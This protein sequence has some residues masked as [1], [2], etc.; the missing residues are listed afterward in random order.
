V[1]GPRV[2]TG[3]PVIGA[4]VLAAGAGR[5]MGGGKP[6]R[7]L[8]ARPLLGHVLNR[9]AAAGLPRLVVVGAD[10]DATEALVAGTGARSV[11]AA[12]H[13]AG[14]AASLG[15]GVRAAPADWSGLLVLLGDMPFV[16]AAT[17]R[18]LAA[19]LIAGAEAVAPVHAGRR[20]NPAGF[21]RRHFAALTRLSGDSGARLLLRRLPCHEIAVDDPGIHLDIDSPAELAAARRRIASA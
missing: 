2:T 1:A 11:Y 5:R 19:G 16:E 17:L 4:L 14:I 9:A 18:R 15:A 21:A 13:G 20:G 7:M 8:G 3:A 6:G 10:R 12:D